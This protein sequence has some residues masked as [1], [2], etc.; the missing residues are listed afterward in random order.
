M[1]A[2]P[3]NFT[4]DSGHYENMPLNAELL[5]HFTQFARAVQKHDGTP[6]FSE[7][8]LVELSKAVRGE[9][10]VHP[11]V[12]A[13]TPAADNSELQAVL[14]AVPSPEDS[15]EPGVLEA[16][17]HPQ[18]RGQGLGPAFFTRVI[19]DLGSKAANYNLWVHGSATDTGIESP[20][21]ELA[22]A[23]GFTPVRVLYKMVLPLD[24]QTRENLAELSDARTL[25]DS[26]ELRTF[27]PADENP[28]LRVNAEAFAEH[29]EQGRLT[30]AD[31]RERTG[32]DWFRPEGFFIISEREDPYNIAAFTWTKIPTAQTEP[33]QPLDDLVPAGEIYVV[34][35]S[36]NAQ[37]GG[38][39]RTVTLRALAY[40]ALASD[41]NGEPL[42]AIELYVDA[43]N[44]PALKLYE[45]LGFAVATVDRMYAPERGSGKSPSNGVDAGVLSAVTTAVISTGSI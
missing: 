8:T 36:P 26:L 37:G 12:F 29:P 15:D 24:E 20:A 18:M 23:A 43:D 33:G 14:V 32:S 31:L 39:G 7:Q 5:E 17:V 45:S 38:L 27:T 34:G 2:S 44:A 21:N 13:F 28:W 4:L 16:A 42:H 10:L 6:A 22:E 41:E 30:L 11:Q 35:V 25:P 3:E 9:S 40:L 19:Q 1:A